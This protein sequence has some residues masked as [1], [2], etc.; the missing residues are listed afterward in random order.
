VEETAVGATLDESR[1]L[2]AV[3]AGEIVSRERDHEKQIVLLVH[4]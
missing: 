3:G 2:V 1:R 4:G